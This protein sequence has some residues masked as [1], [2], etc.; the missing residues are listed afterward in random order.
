MLSLRFWLS[1]PDSFLSRDEGAWVLGKRVGLVV[2]RAVLRRTVRTPALVELMRTEAILFLRQVR[3]NED[4]HTAYRCYPWATYAPTPRAPAASARARTMPPPLWIDCRG[5]RRRFREFVQLHEALQRE[6]KVCVCACGRVCGRVRACGCAGGC[7]C[8]MRACVG[9]RACVCVQACGRAG[10]RSRGRVYTRACVHAG[11]ACMRA[12]VWGGRVCVRACVRVCARACVRAGVYACVRGGG[13]VCVLA[14]MRVC[15][16]VCVVRAG[17]RV[18]V[19]A[20]TRACGR[21]CV[22]TC[23]HACVQAFMRAGVHACMH[24]CV[25]ACMRACVHACVRACRRACAYVCMSARECADCS[26][27]RA[28]VA[29]AMRFDCA[30][31]TLPVCCRCACGPITWVLL[32]GGRSTR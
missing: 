13:R 12:C 9:A 7:V 17:V 4:S 18:G 21:V 14:C 24:A 27:W 29:H 26:R 25:R 32:L 19:R 2:G 28:H 5:T 15:M 30:P 31:Q 23:V 10:V 1:P 11:H 16:R 3:M 20:G 6:I 22:R 8:V